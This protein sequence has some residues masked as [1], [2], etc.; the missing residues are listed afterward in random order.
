MSRTFINSVAPL[1]S[2]PAR[3][4]EYHVERGLLPPIDTIR[5]RSSSI[6]MPLGPLKF[7]LIRDENHSQPLHRIVSI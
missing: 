3:M 7:Q 4:P 2:V 1:A 5:A 6:L